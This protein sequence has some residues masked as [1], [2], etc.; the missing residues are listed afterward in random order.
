MTVADDGNGGL[1]PTKT[2]VTKTILSITVS[3]KTATEMAA[4]YSFTPE[5]RAQ[6]AK[7]LSVEYVEGEVVHTV[8]GNTNDSVVRRS[9][10][11]DSRNICGYGTP[12]Y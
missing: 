5:Q 4:H 1:T 6:L 8:E 11:L 10:R 2:T 7:L 12:M 9:Y 3:H